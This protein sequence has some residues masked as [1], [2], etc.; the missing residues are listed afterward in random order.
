[1]T[2]SF[3]EK[4]YKTGIN[5][6]VDVPLEISQKL[7][8]EK[9]YIRIKGLINNFEFSTTLVPVKNAPHR[10]F[11]NGMMMKGG[12]TALGEVASFIISQNNEKQI[13]EYPLPKALEDQLKKH[14]LLKTFEKLTPHRKK[15]IIRY[16]SFI[17]TEETMSRNIEKIVHQLKNKI[18]DVRIPK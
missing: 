4:I 14:K 8:A 15:E 10:L 2:Y 1:M 12:K 5:W 6:A 17:K 3:S 13:H 16:L 11:V 9:G 18:Q 7:I